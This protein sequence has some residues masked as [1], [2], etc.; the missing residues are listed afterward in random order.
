[1][2]TETTLTP[3][4]RQYFAIK[5]RFSDALVFFQVGDFYELFFDDAHKASHFLGIVLTQRGTMNNEP[6]PL[7]GVPR[8]TVEHYIVK[9]IKGGFRVVICDQ[10]EA[11]Q[12]G[13]IVERGVT[14]VFT[15]GTLTDAKLLDSKSA[16]YIAALLVHEGS[17]FLAFYEMLA[18]TVYVTSFE[19]DEKKLDAELAVFMPREILVEATPSGKQLAQWCTQRSFITTTVT[20]SFLREQ[21]ELWAS[22]C[23]RISDVAL[24]AGQQQVFDLLG[25]YISKHAPHSLSTH[26]NLLVYQAQ[27]FMQIDAATQKNLELVANAHD[28]STEHTLF[29][30]LDQ[31]MTGMGSR[32]IKK[33]ILRPLIDRALLEKRLDKVAF[34][35]QN[36]LDRQEVRACL[37]KIGDLERVVGRLVLR[38]GQVGDYKSVRD[39]LEHVGQLNKYCT[40]DLN[41][42]PALYSLLMHALNSNHTVDWKIGAGY[43]SELDRLR[44][45]SAQGMQA[46]FE[47]ER[48]EQQKSGIATL[49]IRYS[50]AAGYAIE[51]S[52]G[53]A[54]SVPA[55]YIKLQSLTN[56][57][58]FTTQELKDL[59]YDM[60]RAESESVALENQLFTA[61]MREVEDYLPVLKSLVQDL[62]EIDCFAAL[63]QAAVTQH[64]VRP[65][66]TEQPEMLIQQGRHPVVQ[67]RMFAASQFVPNDAQLTQ[68]QKTWIIT[69]PNMGGKSTY[70]RQT[71]L[72]ALLAQMGSFVPASQAVLPL[73]DHIF[74]RIGAGDHLAEGK[75]TFLVEMEE[76]ALIC[77]K[78][79]EK[80]L[81]ILDE[82]G[83]GT[84][85]YDGL[86]LAQAIVEYL[87]EKIKPFC[88]FA[89]HYHELTASVQQMPGIVCYHAASK[90]VGDRVILLHKILPGVAEGSFGI[91]VAIAAQVPSA[92]IQRARV[93][94][95][96]YAHALP[97]A[98]TPKEPGC[99][100][101]SSF[102]KRCELLDAVNLDD[103]SPR[104]AYDLLCRLK[105]L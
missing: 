10:L 8:H 50:Q 94:L 14:Q 42:L 66:F 105:E 36:S 68:A 82:V 3:L 97:V 11:P 30:V 91:Q 46:I 52:K 22:S 5:D 16:H 25:N 39:A 26:K 90:Q 29:H 15:P 13:K 53:Q 43:H 38:K 100:Q 9:L 76:T 32:L 64:W 86:S 62:A 45:L 44:A 2:A 80:S 89:T 102:D 19:Y 72:I 93:L 74:T 87:H 4:M 33:Y 71:A 48:Q 27:D 56:R 54:G 60:S 77:H 61:L 65:T 1:M 21:A 70:L 41:K 63:A 69:G 24:P 104:Q 103:L 92:I 17:L 73:L 35:A 81:V 78:A 75:S 58:R 96:Q 101:P 12:P 7:C 98:T 79:T 34:F 23:Q 85:T 37:K 20:D 95:S 18:A 31:A 59:E 99:F 28:G 51:V 84:S 47:L 83:R 67:A 57:D 6:I 40:A 49:K 55:H 88:L